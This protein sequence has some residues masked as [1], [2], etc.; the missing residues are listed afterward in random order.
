MTLILLASLCIS[1]F[2]SLAGNFR[3]NTSDILLVITGIII[4]AVLLIAISKSSVFDYLSSLD[5]NIKKILAASF[6]LLI[7][8]VILCFQGKFE[9]DQV[10][11]E[12]IYSG[13]SIQNKKGNIISNDTAYFIGKT[14][15]Y[16]FF[17]NENEKSVKVYP[18]NEIETINYK[19]KAR[20]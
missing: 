7:L 20:H 18:I 13:T 14:N 11:K 19:A 3:Y 2:N 17:Y 1:T 4:V 15:G 5:N 10:K 6:T 12:H 16:V 9:A 8:L